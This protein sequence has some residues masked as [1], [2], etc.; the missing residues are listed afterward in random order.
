MLPTSELAE[1]RTIVLDAMQ[2]TCTI[3]T[4]TE[5]NTKGSI[6]TSFADTYTDVQCRLMPARA[7]AREYD[8]GKVKQVTDFVLTVPYD[9]TIT[10]DM[11]VVVGSDTYEVL[12][13]Y[14]THS[15]RTANRADLALS[16]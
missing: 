5:T 14:T 4:P 11:R 2:E 3:Q 12:G 16:K 9:Q 15:Y 13:V 10:A 8:L 6:S 1:L 7:N